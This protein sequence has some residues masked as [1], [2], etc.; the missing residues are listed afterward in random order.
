M[1]ALVVALA[2][3]ASSCSVNPVTGKR[4][5]TLITEAQELQMGKQAAEE[6]AQTIGLYDSPAAQRYVSELG[7]RLAAQS[8]RPDLPWSFQVVD[9]PVV[10]AFALPGG[11]IFITRGLMTH[12][13][14]EAQ[15]AAVLGHEIGHV[16]ARHSVKMMSRAQLAQLG[17]VVGMVASE[18]MRAL[19][20]NAM[21]GMQLLFLKHGRDAERQADDL[22]YNYST[23]TGYDVRAMP[24]VFA[25]LKRVGEAAG[26]ERLP[27]WMS[28]HPSPDE[29]IERIEKM[30]AEKSP[31]AG[32]LE[33]DSYLAVTNGMAYGANPRQGFFEGG[34]FKH[35]ELKFQIAVPRGWKAQNL[36]QA[37]VAE[38][39]SGKAGFQ[40]TLAKEGA[41]SQ[42]LQQ[43][44]QNQAISGVEPVQLPIQ[45]LDASSAKFV[46]KTE[47]GQVG[48]LVTFV[49][50]QGKTFQIMG[51]APPEGFA[52]NEAVFREAVASF[53]PLTDPAALNVQPARVKV[54]SV[55]SAMTLSEF[56][57]RNNSSLSADKLGIVNQIEASTPLAAGQKL[58]TVEGTVRPSSSGTVASN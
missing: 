29:R 25:T 36:A 31:P 56:A 28:S 38:P 22:G 2:A 23:S 17:L 7:K 40:L 34:V 46:A 6:V 27:N 43:F 33:R 1:V 24:A 49:A 35:P 13:N 30:I 55:P 58:K 54:V 12:M 53:R 39:P 15:L 50:Y 32:K 41:P 44:S 52:A 16:T 20:Q 51:L 14:N 3:A 5:L 10:N 11:Y 47:G 9:D 26:A 21:A 8:E 19:G 48:G 18:T 4:E 57:S 45:G 42:A 37:V